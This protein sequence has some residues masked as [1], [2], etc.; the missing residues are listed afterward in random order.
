MC[1]C[2]SVYVLVSLC[3]TF[4][5]HTCGTVDC[6]DR[7]VPRGAQTWNPGDLVGSDFCLQET[8]G[9]WPHLLGLWLLSQIQ[10]PSKE[11]CG[12]Q[13]RRATPQA[14]GILSGLHPH[15]YLAAARMTQPSIKGAACPLLTLL[16]SCPLILLLLLLLPCSPLPSPF[17]PCD[18]E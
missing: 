6:T 7:L 17:S 13:S 18:H 5:K 12:H 10:P 1:R 4:Y 2:V 14:P 9:V 3:S 8:G 11:V 15:S 16:L